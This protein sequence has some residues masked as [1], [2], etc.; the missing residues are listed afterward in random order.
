VSEQSALARLWRAGA[1]EIEREA[2][3]AVNAAIRA[4]SAFSLIA[5]EGYAAPVRGLL[6]DPRDGACSGATP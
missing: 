4:R 3:A 6:R 1:C 2:E 5:F